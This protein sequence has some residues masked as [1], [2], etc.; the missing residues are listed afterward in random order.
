MPADYPDIEYFP[1]FIE[2]DYFDELYHT[3]QWRT[4]TIRLFGKEIVE[5]RLV[6]WYG[7]KEAAYVYSGKPLQPL[8]WTPLLQELRQK[9][10]QHL[11]VP[12]NAVLCN[13]YRDGNDYM[14]WHS[15]NE[16][17]MGHKPVI[18]SLSFGAVRDFQLKHR[19]NKLLPVIKLSLEPGSLLVMKGDTQKYWKHQLPKRQSVKA[20]RI[21]LTFRNII[22]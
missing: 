14:G 13:L 3:L 6:A 22:G 11:Q 21:N 18:A 12:F 1:G 10:Q 17:P 9:L 5:P 19:S 15:D 20:P 7:E 8:P 4:G 16:K 2:E